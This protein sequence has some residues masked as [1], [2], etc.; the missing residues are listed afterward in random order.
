M[1]THLLAALAATAIIPPGVYAHI[2][3]TQD[4]KYLNTHTNY[5]GA[6]AQLA[7]TGGT[8]NP[9]VQSTHD[10]PIIITDGSVNVDLGYD[11][12]LKSGGTLS[13]HACPGPHIVEITKWTWNRFKKS[14]ESSTSRIRFNDSGADPNATNVIR[15]WVEEPTQT[16]QASAP[17]SSTLTLDN[18]TREWLLVPFAGLSKQTTSAGVWKSNHHR[19]SWLQ[20]GGNRPTAMRGCYAVQIYHAWAKPGDGSDAEP[21]ALKDIP[22]A[23]IALVKDPVITPDKKGSTG[24][25]QLQQVKQ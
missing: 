13:R 6:T 4:G 5:V 18:S 25:G 14:A 1:R 21:K 7:R 24:P 17:A 8:T 16:V 2:C 19:M 20:V 15:M 12:S 10:S 23:C 9:A 11:P 3:P 22:L